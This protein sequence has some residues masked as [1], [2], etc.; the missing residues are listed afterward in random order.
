MQFNFSPNSYISLK[1]LLFF[2]L[3]QTGFGS[4]KTPE[5]KTELVFSHTE[6]EKG[7]DLIIGVKFDMKK[8]WHIYWKNP[9]DSGLPP[10]LEWELPDGIVTGDI[11]YPSPEKIYFDDLANYSYSNSIILP[12]KFKIAKNYN[13]SINAKLKL[14][15]LTCK[16]ICLAQDTV[17]NFSL[18]FGKSKKSA[19]FNTLNQIIINSNIQFDDFAK[20]KNIIN[21]DNQLELQFITEIINIQS[22]DFFPEEQGVFVHGNKQKFTQTY[23]NYILNLPLDSYAVERPTHL[24]G[25]L[26]I[27]TKNKIYTLNI[28]KPIGNS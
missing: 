6:V 21:S 2:L 15:W 24:K 5:V 26:I 1:L 9:G 13:G 12:V 19:N 3:I 18:K 11:I 10:K 25:L 23:N 20:V 8:H 17:L 16:E 7:T 14:S 22:I 28:N 27:K 4:T